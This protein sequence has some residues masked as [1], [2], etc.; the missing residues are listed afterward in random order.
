MRKDF[1]AA[2]TYFV[3]LPETLHNRVARFLENQGYAAEA[4]QISKDDEH[5]FELALQLG[6]LQM[7][8]DIV[9]NISAQA[10][11]TMPPRG[12]WKTLGDVALEQGDFSLARRCFREAKDLSALF[13]VHTACGDGEELK[14]TAL[15]AQEGGIANIACICYLLLGDSK[16]A[17]QV[18]IKAS[19]LPE[20]AFFARTYCPSELSNVVKL[21]K[22]DLSQV[23]QAVADSLADPVQYPELFPDFE[24]TLAAERAFEARYAKS[25]PLASKYADEKAWLEMDVLEEVRRLSPEGFHKLILRGPAAAPESVAPQA[26]PA[27]VHAP[28]PQQP[29]E[30]VIEGSVGGPEMTPGPEDQD[31]EPSSAVGQQED[32][33]L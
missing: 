1:A 22:A 31:A 15:A 2:E 27:P 16:S 21:W 20:A 17:L 14:N 6:K 23:N 5:R 12:K 9:V 13:L 18:L 26:A 10:N 4:L 7:A 28:P 33:L 11:T 24:L 29:P 32:L 25:P 19:R 8:A 3:Q 30:T